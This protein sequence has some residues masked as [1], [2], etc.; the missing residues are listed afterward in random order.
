[1]NVIR[2][3]ATRSLLSGTPTEQQRPII[4]LTKRQQSQA[5]GRKSP[6]RRRGERRRETERKLAFHLRAYDRTHPFPHDE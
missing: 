3:S 2:P 4:G 5:I 6:L 1:M